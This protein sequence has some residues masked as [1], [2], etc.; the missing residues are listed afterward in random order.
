MLRLAPHVRGRFCQDF[1]PPLLNAPRNRLHFALPDD[2]FRAI[3]G[4]I[5]PD[6]RSITMPKDFGSSRRPKTPSGPQARSPQMRLM[7]DGISTASSTRTK[8]AIGLLVV[9]GLTYL[10][11]PRMALYFDNQNTKFLFGMAKAGVG[12]LA[13]DWLIGQGSQLPI[14][15]ALVFW[16]YA[17]VGKT[18]FHLWHLGF[19]VAYTVAIY[20]IARIVGANA[21]RNPAEN[22]VWF[23]AVFG[24]C[25]FGLNSNYATLKA[26]EG[27]AGQY[28]NGIAFEPQYFG[29]L[30]LLALL[31]FRINQAGWAVA[32]IVAAAWMHSAFS[33]SGLILLFGMAVAKWRFG[34][35]VSL[36]FLTLAAGIFGCLAA[37]G[38]AYSLLQPADPAIQHEAARILTEVRIP[39]HSLP[40]RWVDDS[41]TVIKFIAV[42]AALWIARRDPLSIVLGVAVVCVCVLA[43]WVHLTNDAELALAAPWRVSSILVPAANAILLGWLIKSI[44]NWCGDLFW[45]RGAAIGPTAALVAVSIGLGQQARSVSLRKHMHPPYF[46]WVRENSSEGDV[47]LTDTRVEDF[48]LATGQAQYVTWKTHP[49]RGKRVLEWSERLE[50]ATTLA[51]AERVPC[52]LLEEVSS[53]GVTHLVRSSTMEDP[54]CDGWRVVYEDDLVTI[55]SRRP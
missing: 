36:P 10:V 30:C 18:G 11:L 20:G 48:R 31:L 9:G 45:R 25:W 38:F 39:W 8:V 52:E 27:V 22:G 29:V 55:S 24:L 40:E 7:D 28:I 13:K 43:L 50:K 41:D 44:A 19:V 53:E 21:A 23:L 5:S 14:F 2:L 1:Q 47:F 33:I 34:D 15:D 46:A 12:Q 3:A 51:R 35:T 16:T 37:A 6:A 26:F 32:L 49:Y 4:E 54:Q 17:T 42:L